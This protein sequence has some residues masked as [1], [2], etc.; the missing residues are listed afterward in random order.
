MEQSLLLI[1]DRADSNTL[2]SPEFHS[3][4][5]P[6]QTEVVE[7]LS[8]LNHDR[9]TRPGRIPR[10]WPPMRFFPVPVIESASTR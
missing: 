3:L 2:E 5:T 10:E 4:A 7:A 9:S 6:R 1:P 8:I